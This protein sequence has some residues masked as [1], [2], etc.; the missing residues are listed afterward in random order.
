MIHRDALVLSKQHHAVY[1]V[2]G[3]TAHRIEVETGQGQG[4]WLQVQAPLK[5]GDQLVIRGAETL[6]DGA[7]VRVLSSDQ[8]QLVGAG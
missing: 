5:Q 6:T 2:D 4:A 8:F 1:R 7:K 3:D